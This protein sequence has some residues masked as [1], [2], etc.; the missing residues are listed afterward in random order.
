MSCLK[1]FEVSFG[2]KMSHKKRC[3]DAVSTLQKHT[4]RRLCYMHADGKSI[5]TSV[6]KWNSR[7]KSI[8]D[9]SLRVQR[10]TFLR[11]R[12][13]TIK[14]ELLLIKQM[15]NETRDIRKFSIF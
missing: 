12:N 3:Y 8:F 15:V 10:S 6:S 14:V 13:V 2:A 5:F 9:S 7:G 11:H 1:I 4:S